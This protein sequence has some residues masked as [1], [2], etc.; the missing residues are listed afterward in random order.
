M[1]L[2]SPSYPRGSYRFVDR[3]ILVISC[4]TDP[5]AV[6]ALVPQPLVPADDLVRFEF[7]R[8]PDSTGFGDY[9]ASGQRSS[10]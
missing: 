2:T 10:R 1:P 5:V 9:N 7:I 8:M 3:D 4:H 6:A